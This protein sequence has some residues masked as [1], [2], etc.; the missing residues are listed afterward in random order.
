MLF[1]KQFTVDRKDED[2]LENT[3][4][5][6]PKVQG[7]Y[8]AESLRQADGDAYSYCCN[9]YSCVQAVRIYGLFFCLVI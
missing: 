4:S 6:V 9:R 7:G 1:G 2:S 3:L 5:C 8:S